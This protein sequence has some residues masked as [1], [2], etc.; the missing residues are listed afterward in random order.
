MARSAEQLM[1]IEGELHGSVASAQLVH[2]NFP[3]PIEN[4]MQDNGAYRVDL[5]LTPR[6]RN[7]RACYPQ[8]WG[9][10]RFER[11]G[12]V[13]VFLCSDAAAGITGV[14]LPVDGGWTAQ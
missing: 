7:A 6:P 8:R 4:L 14:S 1:T 12:D 2:F 10:E 13:A 3:A 9:A 11:I 5:C